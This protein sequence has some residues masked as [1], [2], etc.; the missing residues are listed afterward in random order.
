L[1]I[2]ECETRS[3]AALDALADRIRS[4]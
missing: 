2:W 4:T 1:A 3:H